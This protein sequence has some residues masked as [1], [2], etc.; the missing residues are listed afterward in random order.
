MK[1]AAVFLSLAVLMAVVP[2]AMAAQV[3]FQMTEDQCNYDGYI[4]QDE[5]N[6]G[7]L[8]DPRG[9]WGLARR[10]VGGHVFGEHFA[11]RTMAWDSQTPSPETDVGI[12][13]DGVITTSYGSFQLSTTLDS[14]AVPT[15]PLMT[16]DDAPYTNTNYPDQKYDNPKG[17]LAMADNILRAW[18]NR[19]G[20]SSHASA[21]QT[22]M[23]QVA[24]QNYYTDINM[25]VQGSN[26]KVYLYA[27]YD[28][29]AGGLEQVQIYESAD[30]PEGGETGFPA[31]NNTTS[32]NPDIELALQTTHHW[33]M[34]GDSS[35]VRTDDG[36]L[37]TFAD[38]LAL[39]PA[40]KLM[41]VTV[42]V[43]D[44]GTWNGRDAYVFA[45]T[46]TLV[47]EPATMVL[48]GVGV[49]GLVLRRHGRK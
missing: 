15:S 30:K 3:Q 33:G 19:D 35:S 10:S 45:M 7:R 8:Y 1:R 13:D 23:F 29:G 49:I 42:A 28:D 4:S 11:D 24:E 43:H 5:A 6:H 41:G 17:S 36:H 16:T 32:S 2:S 34:S 22:F 46:G 38:P 37:W 9:E 31:W 21:I 18:R 25:L 27:E 40:K 44:V 47:P 39:D 26:E 14:G 12:P 20:L 48:M